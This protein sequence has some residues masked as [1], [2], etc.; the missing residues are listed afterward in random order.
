M[1]VLLIAHRLSTVKIADRIIYME[2]GKIRSMGNFSELRASIPD[3]D[4]Q[5]KLSGL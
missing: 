3:F 5:A 4:K 1:T 2:N